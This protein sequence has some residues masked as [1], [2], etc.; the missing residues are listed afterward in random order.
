MND[1]LAGCMTC[2]ELFEEPRRLEATY[3]FIRANLAESAVE[4]GPHLDY[5]QILS[6]TDE[7]LSEQERSI[8][9]IHLEVCRTCEAEVDDLQR[10]RAGSFSDD[11]TT[12]GRSGSFPV[13]SHSALRSGYGIPLQI[14]LMFAIAAV[15]SVI[16]AYLLQGRLARQ[17]ALLNEVRAR[18]EELV[19]G[20]E[21]S[22]GTVA[23]LKRELE[24]ISELSSGDPSAVR[25]ALNDA[26][27]S[28]TLNAKGSIAGLEFVE[29]GDE[30][31]IREALTTG[32]A[33]T[34][35]LLT[36]LIGKPGTRMGPTPNDSFAL[37]SPVA[38]IVLTNR[39]TL[40]WE[41]L[42]GA[43]GYIVTILDS[44]FN[45]V[46][47]SPQLSETE[48]KPSRPL[49]QGGIYPWQVRALKDGVEI[50]SPS[51]SQGE[52][53]FKVLERSKALEVERMK[54]T[55]ANS[56]LALGVMYAEAGLLEEANREFESLARANP[57][58]KLVKSLIRSVKLRATK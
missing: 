45:E 37:L 33:R 5:D 14:A 53:K 46:E 26:Q 22:K 35:A 36:R 8:V 42:S 6:Y 7:R 38:T 40:K 43:S 54:Q 27:G 34:P 32:R 15:A 41:A 24:R 49:R 58:S 56:H 51:T 30:R 28:V 39:P 31:L 16:T 50:R 9:D 10:T 29:P 20:L 18:G 13:H 57:E 1:H 4:A 47:T 48:W 12:R 21:E 2:R 19:R 17:E 52:A 11:S 55:Y 3:N 44:R 23:E 25:I